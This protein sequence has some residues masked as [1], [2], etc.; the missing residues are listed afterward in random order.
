MTLKD[1]TLKYEG[2]QEY[3]RENKSSSWE[4]MKR[5]DYTNAYLSGVKYSPRDLEKLLLNP[6]SG[7]KLKERV[8]LTRAEI[9]KKREKREGLE[10][11][12][13]PRYKE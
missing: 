10:Y 6:Y 4:E 7:E 12:K 5:L 2:R 8:W 1:F 11:K 9:L 13:H 3:E